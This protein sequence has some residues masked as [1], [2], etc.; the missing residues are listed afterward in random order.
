MEI[1]ETRLD[2]HFV[3]KFLRADVAALPVAN[4]LVAVNR[5][6]LRDAACPWG[7]SSTM[8]TRSGSCWSFLMHYGHWGCQQQGE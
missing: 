2:T 7:S 3:A 6:D 5:E 8:A 1:D 4:T